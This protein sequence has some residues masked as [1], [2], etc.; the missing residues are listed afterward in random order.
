LLNVRLGSF[1][2]TSLSRLDRGTLMASLI[3]AVAAIVGIT[4]VIGSLIFSGYQ[5]RQLGRQL[6]MQNEMARSEIIH[7]GVDRL[8][9]VYR[10]FIDYPELRKYFYDGASCPAR[11]MTRARVL[12][13]A[14]MI[15]DTI[16]SV[17][18]TI[19]L[20]ATREDLGD[21]LDYIGHILDSS[22]TLEGLAL[23]HPNWWPQIVNILQERRR[24]ADRQSP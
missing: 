13:V 24:Q 16:D 18:E 23:E 2:P 4:G 15:G 6:K 9:G 7:H 11:G 14:E 21:W 19:S 22:P 8:S 5:T 3:T 1:V 10:A 20:V 17:L 12:T